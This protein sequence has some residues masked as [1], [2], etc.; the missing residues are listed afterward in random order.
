MPANLDI[1]KIESPEATEIYITATP[2]DDGS[3]Q[4][5]AR[6]LFS[7]IQDV[8]VSQKAHLLHERIFGTQAAM[9]EVL[10]IRSQVYGEVDDGI[11]EVDRDGGGCLI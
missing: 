11:L 2:G 3:L 6:E 1:R 9:A 4:E 7:N 10:S 5:Q 8:L